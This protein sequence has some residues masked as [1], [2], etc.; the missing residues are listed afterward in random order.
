MFGMVRGAND[1]SDN[2]DDGNNDYNNHLINKLD[3]TK[4]L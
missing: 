2:D 3:R 1:T 4:V